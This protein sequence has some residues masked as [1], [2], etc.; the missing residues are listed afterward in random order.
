LSEPS[1]AH[2]PAVTRLRD[3]S[4]RCIPDP[5]PLLSKRSPPKRVA[6][7]DG[8][9][10]RLT[11]ITRCLLVSGPSTADQMRTAVVPIAGIIFRRRRG[12]LIL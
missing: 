1:T 4:A 3:Q 12:L 10:V 11:A 9:E 5:P 8:S 2:K 6:Q 7:R